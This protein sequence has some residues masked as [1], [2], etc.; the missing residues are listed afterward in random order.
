[1]KLVYIYGKEG[2]M[3]FVSHLDL[4]RFLMRALNRTCL[5][6][7]FSKGFN[8]HPLLSIA[9][10]LAMGHE[11]DYEV[12]EVRIEGSIDKD[13]ALKTMRDALPPDMPIKDVLFRE[14]NFPSMM[15]LVKMADYVIMPQA[16]N[17]ELCKAAES[18]KA[19]D[20]V[21]GIRKTKSGEREVDV[22]KLC[23]D[24]STDGEKLYARLML[25]EQDT[26]KP[27]LLIKTLCDIAGIEPPAFRYK[28][29]K[30]LGT[31]RDGKI[32]PITEIGV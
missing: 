23:I 16:S 26:L 12:F 13:T 28:R 8:P 31:D 5:P 11:S 29:L 32:K 24:I 17:A 18:F 22:R 10:A 6:I 4:Q 19:M 27:D 14:D 15:S 3:R 30:L 2:R 7:A 1:M 9:G 21:M 20:S 25:T